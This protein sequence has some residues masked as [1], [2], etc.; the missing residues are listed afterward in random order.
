MPA[1]PGVPALLRQM[2][3]RTALEFI[4]DSGPLTRAELAERTGLSRV[5]ASQALARLEEFGLV[6]VID[7]RVGGRGP[8]TAVP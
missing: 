4:L 8:R 6:E 7:Q 1:Q 3:D 2:N 5:T